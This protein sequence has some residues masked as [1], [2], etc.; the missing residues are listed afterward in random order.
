MKPVA[1]GWI[2]YDNSAAPQWEAAQIHQLARRLG[3]R[4][5]WPE[6]PALLPLADQVRNAGADAVILPAPDQISAFELD[7]LLHSADIE[8]V[9]P[10]MSF[11]RW[12]FARGT[13]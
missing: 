11:A 3:Y 8:T 1:L 2:D 7:R 6:R 12:S 10:R 4:L 5:V 9:F 13:Q